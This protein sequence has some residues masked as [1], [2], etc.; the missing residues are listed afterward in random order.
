MSYR[1]PFPPPGSDAVN[2]PFANAPM[3]PTNP[4]TLIPP[5]SNL[6]S[7]GVFQPA[8]I[9]RNSSAPNVSHL[10]QPRHQV[11]H[12][13]QPYMNGKNQS[14]LAFNGTPAP[15][16]PIIGAPSVAYANG[17][18]EPR[19]GP[20][21]Q[22]MNRSISSP[23]GSGPIATHQTSGRTPLLQVILQVELPFNDR[24]NLLVCV[25]VPSMTS[26]PSSPSNQLNSSL[27]YSPGESLILISVQYFTE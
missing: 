22:V 8:E 24:Y 7:G 21:G 11:N 23:P 13:N 6:Q 19:L 14:Q 1:P 27:P 16:P 15:G 12:A 4:G 18:S 25:Q 5:V 26:N 3:P 17:P 9:Q 20:Q 2:G 10:S